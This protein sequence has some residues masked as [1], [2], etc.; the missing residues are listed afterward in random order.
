MKVLE[1][2]KENQLFI[3]ELSELE[4]QTP[5]GLGGHQVTEGGIWILAVIF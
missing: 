4:A 3:K 1:K 5:E 2:N